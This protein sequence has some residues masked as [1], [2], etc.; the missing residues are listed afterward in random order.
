[1]V[2]RVLGLMSGSSLDGLDLALVA[3]QSVSGK[4]QFHLEASACYPYPESWV[5]SLRDA[6]RL[7]AREYQL[8]HT[9]YGHY[10]GQQVNRFID[11]YQLQY[12]VQLI[13]SH[14]HTVF[15]EPQSHMTAQLGDGAAI[16]A[17]TGINTVSELRAMDVAL[18][19][20]GAPIV[21]IG[22][23][24]LWPD[25]NYLLNLGGIANLTINFNQQPVAFDVCPANRVLNLLAGLAGKAYDENGALAAQGSVADALLQ[26]LNALPYYQQPPPKSLANSFGT[27]EV[28]PLLQQSGLSV[29]DASRTYVEHIL[30]QIE[31][32]FDGQEP[33][34]AGETF[35]RLLVTG[36]GAHHR[37]L[38]DQLGERLQRRG[39][40]VVIPDA[41]LINYK[42]AIVMALMGVLRWREEYNVLASVTGASR[43]SIGGALWMGAT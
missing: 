26:K 21:P 34:P 2:Y 40:E 18:G 29:A 10:L 36:G 35:L 28:F 37:F 7:H 3:F 13:A 25:F 14:G 12:K 15:H 42:E 9:A 6:H 11:E 22:E 24:L 31:R 16:A 20:Q 4:W 5:A 27:D 17:L 1:M 39:I 33:H 8:L 23:L 30:L 19:G 41:A 32:A 43:N 38:T